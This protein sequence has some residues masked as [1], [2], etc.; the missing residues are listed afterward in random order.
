MRSSGTFYWN[1]AG[2][3][4]RLFSDICGFSDVHTLFQWNKKVRTGPKFYLLSY[5]IIL[6][7]VSFITSFSLLSITNLSSSEVHNYK[8]IPDRNREF[9]VYI[10]HST[11]CLLLLA[12]SLLAFKGPSLTFHRTR[13]CLRSWQS[14][15]GEQESGAAHDWEAA[16][17]LGAS[18]LCRRTQ[19][20]STLEVT[21]PTQFLTFDES[22]LH[23]A[24]IQI[25]R[26]T[27]HLTNK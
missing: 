27:K 4:F 11:S 8:L 7:C 3:A 13:L 23:K 16:R 19:D 20:T 22:Q 9:A 6:F 26:S 1:K 14:S 15:L 5:V 25:P 12:F 24:Q 17:Q 18:P 2:C 21:V 10:V